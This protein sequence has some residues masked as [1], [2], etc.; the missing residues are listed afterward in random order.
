MNDLSNTFP[1]KYIFFRKRF[2]SRG[3]F[4]SAYQRKKVG[5]TPKKGFGAILKENYLKV[6]F[7]ESRLSILEV[8]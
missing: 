5:F 6:F 7:N 8:Y 1:G 2:L 3:F 4:N